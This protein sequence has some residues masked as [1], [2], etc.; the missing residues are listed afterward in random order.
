MSIDESSVEQ[1]VDIDTRL[2]GADVGALRKFA[3]MGDGLASSPPF[4]NVFFNQFVNSP[5]F[6]KR[7]R[8]PQTPTIL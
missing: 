5:G 2:A 8:R 4:N 6:S 3:A 7:L 1:Q